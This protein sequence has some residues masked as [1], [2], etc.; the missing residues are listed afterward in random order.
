MAA[1]TITQAAQ[2]A[3]NVT[4]NEMA[5]WPRYKYLQRGNGSFKNPFDRGLVKNC[6]EV[7]APPQRFFLAMGRKKGRVGFGGAGTGGREQGAGEAARATA[8]AAEA[9]S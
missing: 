7:S 9:M 3:R 6:L 5:N 2:I 4:T 8:A 1:L